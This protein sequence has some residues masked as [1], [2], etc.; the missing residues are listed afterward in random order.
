MSGL[1]LL[2]MTVLQYVLK[3]QLLPL[4]LFI[5]YYTASN[6]KPRARKDRM[7]QVFFENV[8]YIIYS[9]QFP[10]LKGRSI[11][12]FRLVCFHPSTVVERPLV[13]RWVVGSIIHGG[14][15]ELFLVPVRVRRLV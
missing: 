2:Q 4:R 7:H 5:A 12:I 15:I 13:V 14:R 10:Y 11:G 8:H 1:K 3:Q 9:I 6:W